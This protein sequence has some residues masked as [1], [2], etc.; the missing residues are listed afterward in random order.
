MKM[1][2]EQKLR[3][4][5]ESAWKAG[6]DYA[7]DKIVREGIGPLFHEQISYLIPRDQTIDNLM[8]Q[9]DLLKQG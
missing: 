5:L 8:S 9:A 7:T 3:E 1:L 4:M 2:T 6:A